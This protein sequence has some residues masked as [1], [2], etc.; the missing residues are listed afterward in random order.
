LAKKL[1]EKGLPMELIIE[2]TGL[3]A[4]EIEKL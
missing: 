1:K 2:V 3:T 4:E